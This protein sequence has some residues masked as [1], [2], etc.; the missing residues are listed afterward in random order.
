MRNPEQQRK[1]DDLRDEFYDVRVEFYAAKE[2]LSRACKTVPDLG[3]DFKCAPT[4]D[5]ALMWHS[6]VSRYRRAEQSYADI[7]KRFAAA[8]H[9]LRL[10]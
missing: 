4:S 9:D 8:S 2:Q 5:G 10:L 6:A 7:L 3:V 1:L